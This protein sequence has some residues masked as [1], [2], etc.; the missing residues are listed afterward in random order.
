MRRRDS[1]V[2]HVLIS[3]FYIIIAVVVVVVL[4]FL[5]SLC[6][7]YRTKMIAEAKAKLN[8]TTQEMR[9]EIE[10]TLQQTDILVRN[11]SIMKKLDTDFDDNYELIGFM[12][13]LNSF[14]SGLGV[15]ENWD[16][17]RFIIYSQ[18]PTLINSG[19]VRSASALPEF[20]NIV[21]SC[22]IG[23]QIFRW[24]DAAETD[25]TGRR[26]LTLY[27]YIPMKYDCIAE[28][29]VYIDNIL[30]QGVELVSADSGLETDSLHFS[31]TLIDGFL[32]VAWVEKAALYRQYAIYLFFL[33]LCAA[34][35]L[36]I[37]FVLAERSVNRA[38]K[39]ILGLIAEI[40]S[41]DIMTDSQPE[42]WNELSVIKKK[43]SSLTDEL[44]EIR[45]REYE[46]K[47]IRRKLE[48]EVLN[49]K[50]NPHLLYNSLSAIKL[51][52]FNEKNSKIADVADILIDYYRLVL[53]KGEDS[54]SL[55]LEMEYLEKYIEI[56]K[57]SKKTDYEVDFYVCEE[58][59]DLVIP[60][61]LLQPLV[62]NA[63]IHGLNGSKDAHITIS[64]RCQGDK[65][66]IDIS[67]NGVGIDEEKLKNL[68]N[69]RELGYGLTS[70][71]QR[72]DF[73]YDSDY[74]LH[75]ES[76]PGQG[77]TA[78]LTITKEMKRAI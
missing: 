18:N 47:L 72:A 63:I 27:R 56:Y 36:A 77:T 57:I 29:K 43:I 42:R 24:K 5:I 37:T 10:A 11:D 61:M 55:V 14:V 32:L 76:K 58:A 69:Y 17:D 68:N 64:V 48:V 60:H 52:A 50:I 26:Y 25:S 16:I 28:L 75:I 1:L 45:T 21:K 15:T 53:N 6:S 30:P 34:V 39:D 31:D 40:E 20:E 49:A 41:G 78:S 22:Q 13:E 3:N 23:M 51:V 70:V 71:I 7:S 65:L 19:Y 44:S 74:D 38:M 12:S 67:D 66:I 4:A 2:G 73:Y 33:G 35:F 59:F 8:D 54:I 9:F 46:Y 62:E